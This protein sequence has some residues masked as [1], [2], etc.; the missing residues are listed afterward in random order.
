MEGKDK[1]EKTVTYKAKERRAVD[2]AW[3]LDGWVK[4][5]KKRRK[6][7]QIVS[8]EKEWGKKAAENTMGERR[9]KT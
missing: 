1:E 9:R 3:R 8:K 6:E 2:S 4:Y 7:K 5:G